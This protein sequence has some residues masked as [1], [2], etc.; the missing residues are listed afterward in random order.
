MPS[1]KLANGQAVQD[2]RTWDGY[3]WVSRIGKIRTVR[4]WEHFF[5]PS[6]HFS[7]DFI[8]RSGMVLQNAKA[9]TKSAVSAGSAIL[10]VSNT[11]NF[12][13]GHEIT[14]TDGIKQEQAKISA[15]GINS[16]TVTA[17][18]NDYP[19]N[20]IVARTTAVGAGYDTRTTYQII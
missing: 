18:T 7:D 9:L 2:V 5:K 6:P 10:P 16:L 13:V 4:G 17:L 3:K 12:A 20:A 19:Q 11:S 15:V 1:I 14:I 8:N